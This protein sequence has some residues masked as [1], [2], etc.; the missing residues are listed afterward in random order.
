[1]YSTFHIRGYHVNYQHPSGALFYSSSPTPK[2]FPFI[3]PP[4]SPSFHPCEASGAPAGSPTVV[5]QPLSF[6]S[7]D[8][9]EGGVLSARWRYSHEGQRERLDFLKNPPE[10]S[11]RKLKSGCLSLL[12]WRSRQWSCAQRLFT[13]LRVRYYHL[14]IILR[15]SHS[16]CALC[17]FV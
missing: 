8:G 12:V 1:M 6:A 13:S 9:L 2:E 7:T 10:I 16:L 15:A 14:I 3:P 11:R 4:P 5:T 17:D